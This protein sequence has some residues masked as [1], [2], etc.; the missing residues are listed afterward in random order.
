MPVVCLELRVVLVLR[1]GLL[2]VEVFVDRAVRSERVCVL[3]E[4]VDALSSF[5]LLVVVV[6][7]VVESA[8]VCE[9]LRVL[10][11]V[12]EMSSLSRLVLVLRVD[13]TSEE[14]P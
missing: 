14:S 8:E 12:D 3:S 9:Q 6:V 7:L 4:G 11:E 2:S 5:S 10:D 13:L 1:V